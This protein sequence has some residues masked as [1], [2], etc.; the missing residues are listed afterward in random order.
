MYV[1]IKIHLIDRRSYHNIPPL[2]KTFSK[3]S[4]GPLILTSVFC[5]AEVILAAFTLHYDHKLIG[6][7]KVNEDP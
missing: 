3:L 7:L 2:K 5:S 1:G 4:Q 6:Y